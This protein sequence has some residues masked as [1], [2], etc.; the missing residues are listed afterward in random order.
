MKAV[1][2]KYQWIMVLLV[3][4]V[5]GT[6]CMDLGH[7]WGD[8]FALYLNQA[9]CWIHGGMD[10][11]QQSNQQCMENS[12]GLVGPY[13]YPQGFPLFLSFFI[14]LFSLVGAQGIVLLLLLKVANYLV[15]LV[16]LVVFLKLLNH[17]FQGNWSKIFLAFVLIAWH[18]KIW[19]AADRLTSDLW[20]TALVVLFFHALFLPF[21]GWLSRTSTLSL[22]VLIAT[23]TRSNGVFLLGAWVI[24][25]FINWK[26]DGKSEFR[27]LSV[28]MGSVAALFALYADAGNGSNHWAL[29]K[30][31]SIQTIWNN[32]GIYAEMA[33]SSPFWHLATALKLIAKPLLWMGVFAFWILVVVGVKRLSQFGLVASVFVFL[34]FMLYLVWPSVQGMR[35]LFPLLPFLMIFFVEGLSWVWVRFIQPHKILNN[36][37]LLIFRSVKVWVGIGAGFVLV[38]GIMTSG[39]YRMRDTNQAF[40]KSMVGVYDFVEKVATEDTKISFHKPRLLHY[41]TGVQAYKIATNPSF[42]NQSDA[43]GLDGLDLDKALAKLKSHQIHYWILQKGSKR[44]SPPTLKVVYENE[45]FVIYAL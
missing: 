13:L 8:D 27:V 24:N 34:N 33:G 36:S 9:E 1:L 26:R 15:F 7:E 43:S 2:Q 10:A 29:L 6:L 38:Q 17:V 41:T 35:F 5:G 3:A 31:I 32:A 23:A 45:D 28:L 4:S 21:K 18:P 22:L 11:L 20:F 12:D 25:D 40:S 37:W 42:V 14:R 16:V 39:F 44:M 30:E 19:E